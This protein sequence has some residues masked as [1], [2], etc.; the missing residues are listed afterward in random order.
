MKQ[1]IRRLIRKTQPSRL[2]TLSSVTAYKQWAKN[3]PPHPHNVL[4]EIEQE[5]V[6]QLLPQMNDKIVLDLAC[7]TG[8]YGLF[9]QQQGA[10]QVIGFDNSMAMLT[11]GDLLQTAC[12]TMTQIPLTSSSIDLVICGLAVGH[13]TDIESIMKEIGR[14]LK[15]KG[16]AV[17]SDFHPFQTLQGHQRTFQSDNGVVAVEH[18]LHLYETMHYASKQANL[19][20]VDVREPMWQPNAE[21]QPMPIVIVY[22]FQKGI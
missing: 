15:P 22:R 7:G 4:M 11:A 8:R 17:I 9:A 10:K 19:Q 13:V 6:T 2:P 5:T 1:F 18:Y 3:Y 20:L 12:V 14:I 21:A 16:Q